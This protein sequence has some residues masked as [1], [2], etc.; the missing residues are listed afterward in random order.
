MRRRSPRLGVWVPWADTD[1]IGWVRYSLD[2]RHIPYSYVRDEDIRARQPARSSTTCCSTD[3]SISSWPS[4]SRAFP[5]PGDRCRSRRPP[6]RRVSARRRSRTTS[7]AASARRVS[8]SCSGSSTTAVCWSRSA[9]ARCWRSRA[10]SCAACAATPAAC[11]AARRAAAPPPPPPRSPE[12]RTPGSHVRVTF[13]RPDHP[14]AY[15]YPR[16]RMCS[17]R[18]IRCMRCRAAGCG[19][20]TARLAS[21]V[22]SIQRSRHEW[23]DSDGAPLLVSGQV[24]GEHDLIGQPAIFDMPVGK[25]RVWRS[26]SIRCTAT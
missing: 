10:A 3:T 23:G 14:I 5:K 6:R 2:Q 9:A 4:R 25:G 21:T 17:A 16:T 8:R 22:R 12:T 15:G 19:W 1:T 11:R 7:P 24:W 26:I 18:T 13:D 20:P